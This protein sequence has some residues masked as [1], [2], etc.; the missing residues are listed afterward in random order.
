MRFCK[1]IGFCALMETLAYR[2]CI[3]WKFDK[4]QL[5]TCRRCF[6]LITAYRQFTTSKTCKVFFHVSIRSLSTFSLPS[7]PDGNQPGLFPRVHPHLTEG[8]EG[9]H[10]RRRLRRPVP[11]EWEGEEGTA[12]SSEGRFRSR[13]TQTGDNLAPSSPSLGC[14]GG[15]M[16]MRLPGSQNSWMAGKQEVCSDFI[17]RDAD[18]AALC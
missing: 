13:S 6:D 9:G 5:L 7:G 12:E 2:N 1:Y 18:A 10:L 17:Q 11:G 8:R 16:S 14:E 4:T 3:L 15:K